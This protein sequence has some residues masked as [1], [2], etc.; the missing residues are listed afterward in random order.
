VDEKTYAHL[1]MTDKPVECWEVFLRV[2]RELG[3]WYEAES[4]M[5][6]EEEFAGAAFTTELVVILADRGFV[7]YA[8]PNP[9]ALQEKPYVV[10]RPH[11]DPHYFFAPGKIEIGLKMQVATNRLANTQLDAYDMWVNPPWLADLS[12]VDPRLLRLGPGKVNGVWGPVSDDVIQQ[13]RPDMQGVRDIFPQ[14]QQLWRWMQQAT[15]ISED[16][17]QGMSISKRQTATEV[18]AR[19]DAAGVRLGLEAA[20]AEMQFIEPLARAWHELNRQYL[21]V[22]VAIDLIGGYNSWDEASGSF[23]RE[24]PEFL[25]LDEMLADYDWRATGSTRLLGRAAKQ[26]N[27]MGLMQYL[28]FLAQMMPTF[29]GW[30]FGRQLLPLFDITNVDEIAGSEDVA[31]AVYQADLMRRA[32]GGPP[33]EKGAGNAGPGPAGATGP[34]NAQPGGAG[35]A[36][37]SGGFGELPGMGGVPGAADG[38]INQLAALLGGGPA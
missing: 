5:W 22:E 18:G 19:Q 23:I 20:L 35:Q 4:G 31:M 16:V 7:L 27:M 15:G 21:P 32:L 2:P 10:Y 37:E 25:S 34:G 11:E 28:P 17:S 12:R 26:Q 29:N 6:D 9:H 1:T 13:L 33:G 38:G 8:G 30:A 14:L 24:D 3:V 36:A